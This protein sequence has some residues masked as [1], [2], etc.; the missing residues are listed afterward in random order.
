MSDSVT[1]WT[2]AP[3][4]TLCSIMS[5]SL[6]KFVFIESVIVSNHL[7]L[8]R[9]LLLPSI[10][11]SVSIFQWVGTLH[12]IDFLLGFAVAIESRLWGRS[13]LDWAVQG[14][15]LP[16][17]KVTAGHWSYLPEILPKNLT[18]LNFATH[19]TMTIPLCS[20]QLCLWVLKSPSTFFP[21]NMIFCNS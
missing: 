20:F 4:A 16:L 17:C 18:T 11:P 5:Q 7:V 1:P 8:C 12:Q 2:A 3:E 13:T 10:F 6:V 15:D 9:L 19:G 14:A 21:A